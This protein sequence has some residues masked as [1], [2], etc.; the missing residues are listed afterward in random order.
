MFI[1]IRLA[2][3]GMEISSIHSGEAG[4]V[5]L[6]AIY[7][8]HV[9]LKG[10]EHVYTAMPPMFSTASKRIVISDHSI[11]PLHPLHHL[12]RS[13]LRPQLR[14]HSLPNNRRPGRHHGHADP[15]HQR[16]R[17]PRASIQQPLLL[18][19]RAQPLRYRECHFQR[20]PL[21][22]PTTAR[23]AHLRLPRLQPDPTLLRQRHRR[24]L[25]HLIPRRQQRP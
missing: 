20:D 5:L 21:L 11:T 16:H 15:L 22:Y 9:S 25:Q 23:P 2:C 8:L 4:F 12:L 24:H 1:R 3:C 19:L 17:R 18:L 14:L 10:R 7:T 13:H 6:Q